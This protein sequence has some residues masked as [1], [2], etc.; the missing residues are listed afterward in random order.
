MD[1]VDVIAV[2]GAC[3]PERA[4]HA[5]KLAAATNRMLIPA[6]RLTGTQDPAREVAK[7][8]PWSRLP[9][10]IVAEFPA[11]ASATG[12]IGTLAG[13]AQTTRLV[14]V[15]CVV[16]ATHLLNDLSADDFVVTER[17]AA[18]RVTD[19]IARALLAVMQI[20][21]ASTVCL[22]NWEPLPTPALSTAMATVSHLSPRA[23]LQLDGA[24]PI[25][26]SNESVYE[27][28]Q[29]RA[30][31]IGV[32]NGEADPHMTDPRVSALRYEQLR[33]LH[34]ERLKTVLDEQIETEAFGW[35]LRSAG[36]CRFASRPDVH[37][38]WDHVGRT[39]AFHEVDGPRPEQPEAELLAAGQDLALIGLDLDHEGLRNALDG[40]ALTDAELAAGPRE[41]ARFTDPFPRMARSPRGSE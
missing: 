18:G 9:A 24:S 10:G 33:P 6:S 39:I 20:E 21:F 14:G 5:Q 40:A 7:L 38:Q 8:A 2:V 25:S 30:G 41:W 22:V 36:F 26:R 23:R 29:D 12:L 3:A 13:R 16:D 28:R 4:L 32:L 1:R 34:P 27:P 15:H 31:W 11:T 37:L 17:D 19:C 35:V